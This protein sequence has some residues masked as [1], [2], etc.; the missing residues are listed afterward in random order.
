MCAHLFFR[1]IDIF[2][3]TKFLSGKKSL[4]SSVCAYTAVVPLLYANSL[5]DKM[6]LINVFDL[7][8]HVFVY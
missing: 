2:Y 7:K 4:Y 6:K 5:F 1:K 8:L 3:T